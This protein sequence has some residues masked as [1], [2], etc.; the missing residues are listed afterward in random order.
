MKLLHISIIFFNINIVSA[1]SFVVVI[2]LL[3]CVWLFATHGLQHIML[4]CPSLSPEFAQTHV[5]WVSD[6]FSSSVI[7]FFLCPLSF[8]HQGLFHWV[9][10]LHQ[11]LSYALDIWQWTKKTQP[12]C[13]YLSC[14][15]LTTESH[16]FL[17]FW[18]LLLNNTLPPKLAWPFYF[19]DH[20]LRKIWIGNCCLWS[21]M[22]S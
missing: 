19:V 9:S 21:L 1:S 14:I 2:Q 8:L 12:L 6:A 22:K 15:I 20:G 3:S 11:A 5:H 18:L 13:V 10:F 16:E 17:L 7:P 4:P